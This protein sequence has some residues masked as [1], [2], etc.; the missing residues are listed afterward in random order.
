MTGDLHPERV[1]L[2]R[3]HLCGKEILDAGCGGGAFVEFLAGHGFRVTGVD[4][5]E[6]FLEI[7]RNRIGATGKYMQGD[8]TALPF[9]D[10]T[11]DCTYCFDVL[12]H[13]DDVKALAELVRVTKNRVIIAVPATDE[14]A[15][16]G[17]L[18]FHH[19]RDLTHLRTYTEASL[20]TL[21]T[22]AG[23]RSFQI[24]PELKVEWQLAATQHL[25]SVR[26]SNPLR[27]MVRNSYQRLL[28]FMLR[29]ARFDK[30]YTGLAAII[31]LE[32]GTTASAQ[33]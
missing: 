3:N 19:Y 24:L 29:Y 5:H 6:M 11:F 4:Y 2:L 31:D 8:I 9:P 18:T 21:I 20:A 1:Q 22:G 30:I 12:E 10:K 14:D 27:A 32:V 25:P 33:P 23:Q 13:V 15:V 17:G 26:I 7:A 28:R 16:G